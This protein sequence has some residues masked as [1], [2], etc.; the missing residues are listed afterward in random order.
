M[1]KLFER[2]GLLKN[3][4]KYL[5]A[6]GCV[7]TNTNTGWKDGINHH[8][9]VLLGR[10][11]H[12]FICLLHLIELVLKNLLN[13]LLDGSRYVGYNSDLCQEIAENSLHE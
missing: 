8:F 7:G 12:W 9:E 10:E 1:F 13:E 11:L 3:I 2:S 6:L 5:R 4:Q